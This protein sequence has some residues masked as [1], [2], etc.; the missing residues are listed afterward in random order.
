SLIASFWATDFF[1]FWIG[2]ELEGVGYPS[3]AVLFRIL[4]A[5]AVCTAGQRV[6]YQ[7][8]QGTRRVK[9]LAGLFA[10]GALTNLRLRH[11]L[12]PFLGLGGVALGALFSAVFFQA[13]VHPCVLNR[14]LQIRWHTYLRKVVLPPVALGFVLTGPIL[15]LRH[16]PVPNWYYLIGQGLI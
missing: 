16:F 8:L 6:G 10:C 11:F 3:P 13:V 2:S 1:H 12:A 9:L 14:V 15:L 4:V 7:I 5:A